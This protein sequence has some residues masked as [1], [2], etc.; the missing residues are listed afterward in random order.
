MNIKSCLKSTKGRTKKYWKKKQR[1]E[2]SNLK[3][4][5]RKFN[6]KDKESNWRDR[7]NWMSNS[8]RFTDNRTK[9]RRK[10][11]GWLKVIAKEKKKKKNKAIKNRKKQNPKKKQISNRY[12]MSYADRKLNQTAWRRV[13][14]IRREKG[15]S[16]AD[17][18]RGQTQSP[19]G[20]NWSRVG[21]F[22]FEEEQTSRARGRAD[23]NTQRVPL[24]CLVEILPL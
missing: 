3:K 11:E 13:G 1:R 14:L 9:E 24:V 18:G 15:R 16:W 23:Q 22:S 8:R 17:R 21:S 7:E 12:F 20:I 19:R 2:I 5:I 10:G 6:K 4:I